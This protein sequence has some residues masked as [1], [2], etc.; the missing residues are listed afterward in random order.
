MNPTF[1]AVQ[2]K[3]APSEMAE[4]RALLAASDLEF[5]DQIEAFVVCRR[6][7]RL[8]ACAGLDH[9]TIKCVAVAEDARG[10]SLSLK[11]GTEVVNLAA[12]RGRFH[13]FL[14][15]APRNIPFFRGWGFYPLIE[16]P[17][18]VVLMENSPTAIE[19][20]CGSLREQRRP[21]NAIG[22]IVLNANP[23]TLGHRYLVEQAAHACDWLHVFVVGEA[24]ALLL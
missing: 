15:S 11:L 12:A 24:C 21:G 8:V 2:P 22:G 4:V 23:F 14:Y 3:D 1:Y 9:A 6:Q 7:G 20:Y 10:E 19:T 13:L 17:Q 18:Q 16:V 5:D